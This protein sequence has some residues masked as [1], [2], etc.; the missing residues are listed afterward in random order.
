MMF[1]LPFALPI[2][3]VVVTLSTGRFAESA[4]LLPVLLLLDGIVVDVEAA[5]PCSN[6]SIFSMYSSYGTTNDVA[7][8]RD[9]EI[10]SSIWNNSF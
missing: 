10:A 2:P 5:L 3:A 7:S 9:I 4:I 1:V 6:G 8:C